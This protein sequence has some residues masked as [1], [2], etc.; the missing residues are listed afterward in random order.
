MIP[1]MVGK[2]DEASDADSELGE[3]SRKV[4]R[5]RDAGKSIESQTAEFFHPGRERAPNCPTFYRFIAGCYNSAPGVVG[6]HRVRDGARAGFVPWAGDDH[7][8]GAGQ[9]MDWFSERPTGEEPAVPPRGGSGDHNDLQILRKGP[10]L[11]GVIEH[12]GSDTE[13]VQADLASLGA[14]LADHNG[15]SGEPSSEKERLVP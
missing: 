14:A 13:A 5:P 2:L 8:V 9:G 15:D 3:G 10:V 1:V 11:E 12:Q 7:E 6:S 4:L